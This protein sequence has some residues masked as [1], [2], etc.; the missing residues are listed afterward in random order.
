M[1]ESTQMIILACGGLL[2]FLAIAILGGFFIHLWSELA[3]AVCVLGNKGVRESL[4]SALTLFRQRLGDVVLTVL[5]FIGIMI[6]ASM[7][8]LP[9]SFGAG[10]LS[11]IPG[12]A[13]LTLPLQVFVSLAQN[14]LSMVA[15]SWFLAAIVTI[16]VRSAGVKPVA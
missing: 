14:A 13:I 11:S 9:F 15:S 6:A 7:C 16:V 10:V 1:V 12:V 8:L 4:R 2:L 5:V 3:I